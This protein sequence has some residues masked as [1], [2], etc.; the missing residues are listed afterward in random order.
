MDLSN[1]FGLVQ[2]S[3]IGKAPLVVGEGVRAVQAFPSMTP[4][5]D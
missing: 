2:G 5:K 1:W 3:Y 4:L